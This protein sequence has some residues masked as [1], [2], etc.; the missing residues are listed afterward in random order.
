MRS[1][2]RI[3][4][5][6]KDYEARTTPALV[7]AGQ[8]AKALGA[9]VELFHGISSPLYVDGYGTFGV[10]LPQM[11][12]TLRARVLAELE[13]TAEGMRR[14]GI[15][16]TTAAEWDFPVYEAIVR[17][18]AQAKA[19]LIV[20]DQHEGRHTAAGLLH[21]T[22]WELLRLS[23]VPLL[24]IK[25]PGA[26]RRPVI[27]AAVDP[28]HTFSKPAK[29]DQRILAASSTIARALKGTEHVLHAYVP[30]PFAADPETMVSQET[31]ERLQADASAAAQKALDRELRAKR[32]PKA[33]RHLIGRHPADAIAQTATE[34]HSSIVVMGAVSRSGLKRL[35]I[36]NTAERALDLL[37]CDVLVVKP[38]HFANR[39]PRGRRGP[40]VVAF[41]STALPL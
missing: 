33:Q 23:P 8:L 19:D 25:T 17:R 5:A 3:L 22:D 35:F 38:A 12:R 37:S 20:A 1:V 13:K 10:E 21:L 4:V 16:V 28:G 31:V 7:K 24:L 18:A 29:L 27:L 36:G 41:V 34:I 11:E 14:E 39:V 15:K 40:R 9:R 32:I 2:R 26:Y 6:V 30:F